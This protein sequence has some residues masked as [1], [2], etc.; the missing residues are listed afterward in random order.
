MGNNENKSGGGGR[1]MIELH[2]I[3]P[4]IFFN[5]LRRKEAPYSVINVAYLKLNLSMETDISKL[6]APTFSTIDRDELC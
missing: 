5:S 3:Y 4:C 6:E 2:N 1:G